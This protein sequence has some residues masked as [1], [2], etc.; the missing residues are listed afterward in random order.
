MKKTIKYAVAIALLVG[1]AVLA[2]ASM[3]SSPSSS[4]SSSCPS[5]G[6]CWVTFDWIP[7]TGN[8]K[9]STGVNCSARNC[10]V[11]R[12]IEGGAMGPEGT[13]RCDCKK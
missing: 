3:G 9:R 5:Y 1:F 6:T 4:S 13:Y 11:N 12:I 10:D 7:R 8:W 2:L